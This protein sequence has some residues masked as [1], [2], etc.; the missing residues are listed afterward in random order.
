[1]ISNKIVYGFYKL[2]KYTHLDLRYEDFIE[3]EI[4]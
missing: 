1:M 4:S 2:S 3:S